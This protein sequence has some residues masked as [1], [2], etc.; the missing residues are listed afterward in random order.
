MNENI[1]LC[2][3]LKD[4]PKGWKFYSSVYGDVEFIGVSYANPVPLHERDEECHWPDFERQKYPIRIKA[5]IVEYGVSRKGRL[6]YGVGE[7]LLFP[8]KDQRDWSKFTVPWYKKGKFD[9]NTLQPFDKVLVRNECYE[10]WKCDFYSHMDDDNGGY[11]YV[12]ICEAYKYCIP[13]NDDT[14]HLVGTKENAPEYYRYWE[15]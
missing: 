12:V 10:R 15:D 6:K 7:C 13:Y 4:C 14:K 8:S 3:I 11:P 2:E 1:N 9:P 5:G